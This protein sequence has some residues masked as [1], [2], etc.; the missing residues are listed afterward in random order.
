MALPSTYLNDVRF[1]LRQGAG[2]PKSD[3]TGKTTTAL[4]ANAAHI[5]RLLSDS[6]HLAS[7]PVQLGSGGRGKRHPR[8]FSDRI[9]EWACRR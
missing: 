9:K 3:K 5:A 1:D 7:W 2:G 8:G 4:A 6:P